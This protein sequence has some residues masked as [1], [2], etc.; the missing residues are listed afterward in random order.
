MVGRGTEECATFR[1]KIVP[2][3]FCS[4]Q[5]AHLENF[6]NELSSGLKKAEEQQFIFCTFI[7]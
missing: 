3:T 4:M 6:R 5:L 2:K 1:R 7:R